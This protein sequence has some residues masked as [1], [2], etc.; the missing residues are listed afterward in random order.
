MNN[1][2]LITIE[3]DGAEITYTNYF[4]SDHAARG[5]VYLSINAG[6]FRLLIPDRMISEIAEWRTAREVI[7]S[8][9]PW[10]DMSKSDALEILFEDDSDNPYALHIASEQAD[11]MPLDTD[12]DRK[13]QPP[14]WKFSAWTREGKTLELPCR[15]RL[16]KRIPWLKS[17]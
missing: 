2:G 3:N 16:V 12:R 1:T 10:P 6:A 15:Y 7:I 5:Y 17:F 11:R 13:D 8:R 14:S 9:G 4:N